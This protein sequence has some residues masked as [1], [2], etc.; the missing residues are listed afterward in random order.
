MIA[1]LQNGLVNQNWP[2]ICL[3]NRMKEINSERNLFGGVMKSLPFILI[4]AMGLTSCQPKKSSSKSVTPTNVTGS[5]SGFQYNSASCAQNTPV[6]GLILETQQATS[7]ISFENQV[8][9][10]LSASM[11]P[12][13]VGNISGVPNNQGLGVTFQGAIILDQNGKVNPSRSNLNITIFDSI[14]YQDFQQTNSNNKA[15]SINFNA[16]SQAQISGGFDPAGKGFVLVQD[17]YGEV[18]FE[19]FISNQDFTGIVSFKNLKN[20][21]GA[22]PASGTLGQ[23]KVS[24][25]GFFQK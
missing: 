6:Q 24:N 12:Q 5:N 14:W 21:T 19:G 15:I 3:S 10:F 18:R 7:S 11:A 17:S 23:F 8:K 9:L 20:V 16:N 25:C 22:A 2:D 13:D 1:S 4:I